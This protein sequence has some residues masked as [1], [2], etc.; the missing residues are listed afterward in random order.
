[1]C[2]AARLAFVFPGQ[3]AQVAGMG[4]A[5]AATSPA[6]AAVFALADRALDYPLSQLCFDGPDSELQRTEVTQPALLTVGEA[7][8]AALLEQLPGLA[9][10]CAAGLSLGEYG[11]LVAADAIAFADAVR[12]VRL[13]GRYMQEAVPEGQ[14]GMTAILGL[15]EAVVRQVCA[16]AAPH[17]VVI[18]A[19]I[20]AP[21]QIVIS[22]E[23]AAVNAASELAKAAGAKRAVALPVSAPFH[24]PLM[25]PAGERLADEL[26]QVAVHPATCP[27]YANVDAAPVNAPEQI[28]ANL[29][30]QVSS[31][32][33]WV[34]GVE[35]MIA[36]GVTHFVE[37]GPGRTV[38]AMIKRIDRSVWVG[39]VEDPASLAEVV[40][41]LR[42][43]GLVEPTGR[44]DEA[45][46]TDASKE[47]VPA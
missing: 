40:A 27:V 34:R 21:G 26:A 9:P 18:P 3:G 41:R 42:A 29:V 46:E 24:S 44:G 39:S 30:A 32:V 8:R 43:D 20:T 31:S 5:L 7:A 37:F 2:N 10:H 13:R 12:L 4:K 33:L 47:V 25:V 36:D 28:R 11:A 45:A 15:D 17:G 16:D 1:M 22:G 6:A 38:A 23:V 19:N 35:A 14:G